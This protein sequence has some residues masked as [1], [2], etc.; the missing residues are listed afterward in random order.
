[1]MPHGLAIAQDDIDRLTAELSQARAQV[2]AVRE[3]LHCEGWCNGRECSSVAYSKDFRGADAQPERC[4]CTACTTYR[5]TAAAAAA[6]DAE[7]RRPLE[8]MI[9]ALREA[10]TEPQ[11][12]RFHNAAEVGKHYDAALTE[13][14]RAQLGVMTTDRDNWANECRELRARIGELEAQVT[15]SAMAE[16]ITRLQ[17]SPITSNDVEQLADDAARLMLERDALE[18]RL[19]RALRVMR[20]VRPWV[21]ANTSKQLRR[22][23]ERIDAI[24]ADPRNAALLARTAPKARP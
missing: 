19:V 11:L 8:Q 10:M 1:M 21:T 14:L 23:R 18:S 4:G 24:L 2:S 15:P 20:D 6:H 5:D 13:P 3:R 9:A 22:D 16:R 7:V 17:V 12:R